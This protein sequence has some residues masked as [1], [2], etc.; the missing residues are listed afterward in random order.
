MKLNSD[1]Q[2]ILL[3]CQS[4]S[5]ESNRLSHVLNDYEVLVRKIYTAAEGSNSKLSSEVLN[6][7]DTFSEL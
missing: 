3:S 5:D 2:K 1:I 7:L 6:L 4:L